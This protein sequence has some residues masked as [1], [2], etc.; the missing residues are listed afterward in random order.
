MLL[1]RRLRS[2][3]LGKDGRRRD[4]YR[5][6]S[7]LGPRLRLG[8]GDT[9]L[10]AGLEWNTKDAQ[11]VAEAKATH[12]FRLVMMCYD[13]IPVVFP[14]FYAE[15]DVDVFTRFFRTAIVCVDRFISISRRT[16][17][18]LVE[19][20]RAQ[21]R[22]LSD[23]RTE[24]LGADAADGRGPRAAAAGGSQRWALRSV[25]VH[26]RAAE[27]PRVARPGL[28]AP[29]RRRGRAAPTAARSCSPAGAAG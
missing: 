10:C 13:M 1:D 21:G 3:A 6:D 16:A 2:R 17:A 24:Q 28:E 27:K 15:R 18:D 22:T 4:L 5:L 23:V 8:P 14:R 20:A 19:F 11:V 26:R 7:V 29:C 9:L 25:R 12:G